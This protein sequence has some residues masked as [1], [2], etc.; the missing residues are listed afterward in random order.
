MSTLNLKL[1]C[2]LI[3]SLLAISSTSQFA[4]GQEESDLTNPF[5][6]SISPSP[7]ATITQDSEPLIVPPW[8]TAQDRHVPLIQYTDILVFA[9]IGH[10]GQGGLA[11]QKLEEWE[12]LHGT[13]PSFCQDG[14]VNPEV[15][16]DPNRF[17]RRDIL[18]WCYGGNATAL[19]ADTDFYNA[20]VRDIAQLRV[21]FC[22]IESQHPQ[23]SLEK[24]AWLIALAK[25]VEQKRKKYSNEMLTINPNDGDAQDNPKPAT[26]DNT[27]YAKAWSEYVNVADLVNSISCRVSNDSQV[28]SALHEFN[29]RFNAAK[30]RIEIELYEGR[31]VTL[32]NAVLQDTYDLQRDIVNELSRM[33]FC[34]PRRTL[35]Q[36]AANG[37]M[38]VAIRYDNDSSVYSG[39]QLATLTLISFPDEQ[40]LL[41]SVYFAR[42]PDPSKVGT[43]DSDNDFDYAELALIVSAN[44]SKTSDEHLQNRLADY[45]VDCI[46]EKAYAEDSDNSDNSDIQKR[47]LDQ[48]ELIDAYMSFLL[49]NG[50]NRLVNN[51]SG[52]RL[53]GAEIHLC[54]GFR[55]SRYAYE[56]LQS[57]RMRLYRYY[58]E[59][60]N[61]S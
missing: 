54:D 33:A 35:R 15:D 51:H 61:E 48:Y 57:G 18:D 39:N 3:A 12:K 56:K 28:H 34:A 55:L 25:D 45:F 27:E 47:K 14:R 42:F 9:L 10:D 40:I 21:R 60:K 13:G 46:I 43:E 7:D 22:R 50:P 29:R 2:V 38:N 31:L 19:L 4:S 16:D 52:I 8:A 20:T 44:I 24:I 49:T 59:K 53:P 11:Q 32:V 26:L 41:D 17:D 23:D 58:V 6:Q 1:L 5:S 37:L 36:A 30:V